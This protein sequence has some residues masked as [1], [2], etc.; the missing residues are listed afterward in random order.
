MLPSVPDGLDPRI[1]RG[2][3]GQDGPP[4]APRDAPRRPA[5]FLDRDGVLNVEYGYVHLRENF[6]WTPGALQALR[7]LKEAGYWVVVV[8]N[9]SGIGRG[10][11][12][13]E[14]FLA[15]TEWM[16]GE[17][18]RA[19]A[20]IDAVYYCPHHPDEQCPARKPSTGM[21]E[22]ATRDLPIDLKRSFLVGD[23][24]SDAEAAERFGVRAV[25]LEETLTFA[26]AV[27]ELLG[28]P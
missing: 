8:T 21:L 4:L 17:T 11:Y 12:T 9:Q 18:D 23:R 28:R 1:R 20:R 24:P 25:L 16:L 5:A 10:L 27:G 14:E 26:E 22:R 6:E 2:C 7:A 13:E 19:G 15:L 3:P